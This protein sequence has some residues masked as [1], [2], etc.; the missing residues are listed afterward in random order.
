MEIPLG[1]TDRF[2]LRKCVCPI[3]V[4][5][6][7]NWYYYLYNAT[8][9][10]G[11]IEQE[12]DLNTNIYLIVIDNSVELVDGDAAGFGSPR[13]KSGGYAVVNEGAAWGLAAHELGHVFGLGHDFRD[14]AYIMSYGPGWN[15]LSACAA[16]FLSVHPY[17]NLN[18]PIE[19]GTPPT[20]ELISPL[21]YPVGAQSVPVQ[22][23]VND[24]EGLHQVLL[25]GSDG[26]TEC[27]GLAGEK[28]ALIEFDYDGT[29]TRE[30]FMS[31]SDLP[32]HPVSVEVVDTYGDA[33]YEFFS[34][35]AMRDPLDAEVKVDILDPNLRAAIAKAIGVPPSTPIFRGPLA[36]LIRLEADNA[37]ISNLTGLEGATN[38]RTLSLSGNSVSDLSALTGLTKLINLSLQEN[39]ISDI[40]AVAGLTNLEA[41]YLGSNNISDISAVADLTNLTWLFLGANNISDISAVAGLT[42]LTWLFLNGNSISDISPLTGLTK[43][44]SLDLN[45]NSIS[46]ISALAGLTNLTELYLRD[47]SVSDI[48][49]LVENTGLAG[50]GKV[51]I[52]K[53]PL[54]YQSIHTH[55]PIL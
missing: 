2:Y 40:S 45:G 49:P 41:L 5:L 46:D 23:K 12:F 43:L 16:E 20:I 25:Y 1:N 22:L 37:N 11:E 38:L 42:N 27:R 51:Y 36:Y 10:V 33:N 18:I 19:E 28:D 8:P 7:Q 6:Y 44:W 21:T 53:N 15:R 35:E 9:M 26:L 30:G 47:N 31:P 3:S 34:L 13:G 50:K 17:F 54:S 48:S 29:F 32:T 52:W 39:N 55:I 4:I 14:G 24:L